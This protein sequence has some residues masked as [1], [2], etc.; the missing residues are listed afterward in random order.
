MKIKTKTNLQM[1]MNT[2]MMKMIIL[3]SII[4]WLLNLNFDSYCRFLYFVY[5]QLCEIR[6]TFFK[7]SRREFLN[8]KFTISNLCSTNV[9]WFVLLHLNSRVLFCLEFFHLYLQEIIMLILM[10]IS[11]IRI[12]IIWVAETVMYR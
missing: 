12:A 3:E 5:S 7:N 1:V 9:F 10:L 2:K 6:I 11:A 8:I 4:S